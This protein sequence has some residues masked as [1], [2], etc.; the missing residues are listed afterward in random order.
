MAV[1]ISLGDLVNKKITGPGDQKHTHQIS[2]KHGSGLS[3][4]PYGLHVT[5]TQKRCNLLGNRVA[6][7]D[8]QGMD[9]P[10]KIYVT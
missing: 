2:M 4:R 1:S 3:C 9:F 8:L 7:V 10:D 5:K 6:R